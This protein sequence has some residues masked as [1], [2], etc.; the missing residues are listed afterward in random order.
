MQ[1][2]AQTYPSIY[3]RIHKFISDDC[4][5]WHL[6][7]SMLNAHLHA[8]NIPCPVTRH[9]SSHVLLA[10]FPQDVERLKALGESTR[11]VAGHRYARACISLD[12]LHLAKLLS[13]RLQVFCC[14]AFSTSSASCQRNYHQSRHRP[15]HATWNC[16]MVSTCFVRTFTK[17]SPS[18]FVLQ[19]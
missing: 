15:A 5:L 6:D 17:A 10:H 12:S 8:P 13:P 18:I 7:I 3:T 14:T 19:A 4:L 1:T 11:K 2:F 9:R 16:H